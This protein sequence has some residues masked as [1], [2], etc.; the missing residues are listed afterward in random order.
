MVFPKAAVSEMSAENIAGERY[1]LHAVI[2]KKGALHGLVF[3]VI[4]DG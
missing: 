3:A 4:Y 1:T 2:L